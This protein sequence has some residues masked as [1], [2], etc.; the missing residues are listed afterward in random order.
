MEETL[1]KKKSIFFP[2]DDRNTS[3]QDLSS[4][5]K[6]ATISKPANAREGELSQMEDTESEQKY[7]EI[8][9]LLV[10]GGYFR[11]RIQG[12]SP[13]DKVVGGMAW[14]ITASNVDVDGDLFFQENSNIGQRIALSEE[15]I[16]ALNRMKCPFPLQAQQIQGLNYI[17]LFPIIRWLIA[18]VIETREE[19]GDLLRMYSQTMFNKDHQAP[20]DVETSENLAHSCTFVDT[21]ED[22]YKPQRKFRRGQSAHPTPQQTLL[23]YGKLHR[24]SRAQPVEKSANAAKLEAALAK[25]GSDNH[26]EEEKRINMMMKG[27]KD[28]DINGAYKVSGGILKNYLPSDEISDLAERYGDGT[29]DPATQGKAFGEK[30]HR[31][32]VAA[33]EKQMGQRRE[34]LKDVLA[35]HRELQERL[36]ELQAEVAKRAAFNERIIVETQKLDALE[37]PENTKMLRALRGLVLLNETLISQEAKFKDSCKRQMLEYKQK[38]DELLKDDDDEDDDRKKQIDAAFATDIDKLQKLKQLL[39]KKNRDISLLQRYLDEL[40]SRAELLQYQ[41]MFV[42]L[43]EQSD[44]KLTETRQ[45]YTTYNTLEDKRALLDNEL[46]ILQSILTKY[47]VAMSSKNNKEMFINSMDNIIDG[48]QSVLDKSEGK[49]SNEKH[50]YGTLSDQYMQLIEQERSYHKYTKEFQDECRKNELLQ[51]KLGELSAQ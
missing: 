44:A 28:V 38:I 23:E 47:N 16:K 30:L 5:T 33:L 46:S 26:E 24:L 11:A 49:R 15:L 4:F 8:I 6:R 25:D 22:R 10:T 35:K 48:I 17:N 20:H 21:V 41:R 42:E 50:K 43:S 31:Q 45:Y 2:D 9:E 19:T 3:Q 13:F 34:E 36:E 40:P 12:L 32:K 27:M 18:K 7:Q 51:A 39:N 14:S 1:K 29:E 37:T